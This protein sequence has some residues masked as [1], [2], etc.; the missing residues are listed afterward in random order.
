M[1][2]LTE[3]INYLQPTGFKLVMD[4]KHF[5]NLTF[6]ATSVIH[7][8]MSLGF[9]EVPFSRTNIRVAGDKLTF[10][11]LQCNIIM[12]EDMQAYQEMYNWLKALVET[13]AVNPRDRSDTQRPT[14]ADIT[15]SALT[16]HNNTVKNIRYINAVPTL[17]GDVSF[18]VVAGD[19]FIVFPVSFTFDYFELV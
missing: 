11:E 5:P 6:F 8:S 19:T 16:S 12:D 14:A 10:G 7:P 4:R 17:L 18:E 9:A 1:A 13:K 15:L 2:T 3:N